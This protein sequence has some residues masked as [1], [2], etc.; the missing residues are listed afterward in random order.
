MGSADV[1]KSM[2][3]IIPVCPTAHQHYAIRRFFRRLRSR[4]GIVGNTAVLFI[5]DAEEPCNSHIIKEVL[6]VRDNQT[7]QY[8]PGREVVATLNFKKPWR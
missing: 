4:G 5:Y 6:D 7:I 3:G 2:D 1:I 8:T